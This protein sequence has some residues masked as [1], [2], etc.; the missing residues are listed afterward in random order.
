MYINFYFLLCV[1]KIVL[2]NVM[3]GTRLL[4]NP[5]IDEANAFKNRFV[6]RH[7]LHEFST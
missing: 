6:D 7:H 3:H 5:D 1:G 2:Q 4:F